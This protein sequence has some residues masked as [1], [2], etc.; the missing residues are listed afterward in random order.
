MHSAD[1][2]QERNLI[3]EA[4]SILGKH[5]LETY[6]TDWNLTDPRGHQ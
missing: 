1:N 5:Q 2:R 4:R 6:G 3:G